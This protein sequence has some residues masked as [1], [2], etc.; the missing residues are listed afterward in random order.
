[1]KNL[2]L[3]FVIACCSTLYISAQNQTE[4]VNSFSE[5]Y[6]K[7]YFNMELEK[8]SEFMDDNMV[9]TDPT[10]SEIDPKNKPITGKQNILNHLKMVSDGISNM[11]YKI[12]H[13][14]QAADIH[15][16]E[17]ILSYSWTNTQGKVFSFSIREVTILKVK[18]QKIIEH[19]DYADFKTWRKQYQQQV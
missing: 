2:I 9:W 4:K 14:F 1:M 6:L 17:G 13:Q 16:F 12:D 19:S 10:W 7:A 3:T 11:S 5:A 18:N 8:S 15:I